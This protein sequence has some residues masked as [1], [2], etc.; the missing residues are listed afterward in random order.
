MAESVAIC[1]MLLFARAGKV[2]ETVKQVNLE[3]RDNG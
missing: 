3:E 1:E 2:E